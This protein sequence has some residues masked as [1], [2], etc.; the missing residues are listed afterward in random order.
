MEYLRNQQRIVRP[1]QSVPVIGHQNVPAQQKP[2]PLS[3][4]P[5]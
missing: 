3:R 1:D 5:A 4:G 2:Q